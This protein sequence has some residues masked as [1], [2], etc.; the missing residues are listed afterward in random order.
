MAN[1]TS[2][3]VKRLREM[4][5]A[6]ILDCKKA[7]EETDGDFEKSKE[8]LRKKGIMKADKVSGREA[9]EGILYSYIHHNK[10]LGVMLE[11]NCNTDFVARTD[12]FRELAHKISLQIA[13]MGARWVSRSDIPEEVT[14]KEREIYREQLKDSGKPEHVVEKILE[15][16]IDAFYRDNTLLDQEYVF[17]SGKTIND[18]I[19]EVIAKTGENVKVSR[20]VRWTVGGDE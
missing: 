18:L 6:G 7:L 8:Y 9:V 16:K 13:S 5:N 15:G 17:E 2:D 3:M 10:K 12:E 1:I 19:I 14:E 20:F 4:T 11:L